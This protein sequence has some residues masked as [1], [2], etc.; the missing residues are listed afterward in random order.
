MILSCRIYPLILSLLLCATPSALSDPLLWRVDNVGTGGQAYLFGSVHFGTQALYPLP[1]V[2]EKAF[3]NS[4]ELVVELD[5]AAIAPNVAA[6]TMRQQGRY[7]DGDS[8]YPHLDEETLSL[9]ADACLELGLPIAALEYLKPWL[10]AVQLTAIQVRSEGF[11]DALGIDRHFIERVKLGQGNG[12]TELVELETFEQQLAIFT[13]FTDEQQ[14]LFLRQTLTE[15]E[16]SS[17][18]LRQILAAWQLGDARVL[19]G[20]IKQGFNAGD[21]SA[22]FY[23]MI[24]ERRNHSMSERIQE[25]LNEGR[26]LFVVVGVGHLV[27]E[28]G[29]AAQLT[30]PG[31]SVHLISGTSKPSKD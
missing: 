15:F 5:M 13:A 18:Q 17:V 8:L 26:Q 22:K 23:E 29:L 11:S 1:D 30:Q 14:L 24:Y 20:I 6:Q 27:G 28:G 3:S 7:I 31:Q 16:F 4:E 25:M 12:P 21:I 2:V 9:L 19:D 10:V